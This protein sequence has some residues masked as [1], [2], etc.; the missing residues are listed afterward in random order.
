[1]W[2]LAVCVVAGL[3]TMGCGDDDGGS[4]TGGAG[5]ESAAGGAGGVDTQE[6][7]ETICQALCDC[8]TCSSTELA[9][10]EGEF[11]ET[12][13]TADAGGC[14]GP[15]KQFLDCYVSSVECVNGSPRLTA[16]DAELTSYYDCLGVESCSGSDECPVHM[17]SDG[18]SGSLCVSGVCGTEEDVCGL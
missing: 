7:A 14:G 17:C 10:C 11:D 6:A 8:S 4:G 1:M 2:K 5:G 13:A 3:L 15:Y 9:G 12:E 16:C 18:T